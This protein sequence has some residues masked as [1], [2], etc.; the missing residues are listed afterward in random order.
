M[1]DGYATIDRVFSGGPADRTGK[2][3]IGDK[4]I[5]VADGKGPFVNIVHSNL[6]KITDMVLGKSGS[7]VRLQFISSST[8]NASSQQVISLAR[9]ER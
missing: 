5:G 1:K 6:D 3:H 8:K 2:L 4:I 7:I 9:A